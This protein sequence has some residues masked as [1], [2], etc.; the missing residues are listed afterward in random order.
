MSERVASAGELTELFAHLAA[1]D[2]HQHYSEFPTEW[3]PPRPQASRP[4]AW[5]C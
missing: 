1:D 5:R 2:A 3:Q 4:A